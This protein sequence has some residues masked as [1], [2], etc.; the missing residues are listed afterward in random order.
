[1]TISKTLS[2]VSRG[3]DITKPELSINY[4]LAA[5]LGVIVLL[6][7]WHMGTAIFNKGSTVVQGKIPGVATTDFKAALGII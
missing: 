6:A 1:M 7:A 5:T 3:A 2:N 4:V